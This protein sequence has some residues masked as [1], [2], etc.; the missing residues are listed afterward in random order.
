MKLEEKQ[1]VPNPEAPVQ[2]FEEEIEE[3]TP[4]QDAFRQLRRNR[5]AI[6][7][8]TII[9]IFILIAIFA[10]VLTSYTYDDQ[11]LVDRLK[12]PSEQ[13]WLGTD[14]LGRD[15]FTR[16]VYGARVS[17]MVGFFAVTGALVLGTLLGVI[18]GYFG[19]WVD[20]LISRI[21]DILLAF[22]SILL[23]IAIVAIL[24]PSLQNALLAIAI[25]NIPIFG[26]LVRSR[27]ISLREEEYIM[28]AKA[29]GMKNG[30]IIFH[31]ILPNSIA[32]II[33]QSTLGFGTAILEAAAL[34]F[35][36][37]GAQPPTPEW[38][39]MLADSRD[40]IQLAPWTVIV[41]GVAIMLVVLGFNLIGDGLR[42]A[43]DPKMKN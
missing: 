40:F 13:Y 29:Q 39:Q 16:L 21:F 22:P 36:G 32:P 23:A 35:L 7:G 20:M 17:L 10:P 42:D 31:H 9:T 25:I 34:G 30:R 26:R 3:R 11:V 19:R 8:F 15:I 4:W 18:A 37:L 6:I 12:P 38:G 41:P 43:L 2:V 14:H 28:A 24:G 27:V 33:V 5:F 1:L